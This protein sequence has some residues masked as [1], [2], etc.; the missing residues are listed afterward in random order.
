MPEIILCF[1]P[2]ALPWGSTVMPK[3]NQP[4]YYERSYD[5]LQGVLY[6]YLFFPR[7]LDYNFSF[8]LSHLLPFTLHVK[9]TAYKSWHQ[10]KHAIERGTSIHVYF[11]WKVY[12][13]PCPYKFSSDSWTLMSISFILNQ[14]L[15]INLLQHSET[16][17]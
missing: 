4:A 3:R 12:S 7:W 1:H 9:N 8:F 6:L 5:F 13:H 15:P 10:L 2:T 16:L 11:Q 14:K 17:F